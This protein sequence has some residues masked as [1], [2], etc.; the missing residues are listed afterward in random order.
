MTR[1]RRRGEYG[2]D[3]NM[4]GVLG[5]TAVAVVSLMAAVTLA[6]AG[7]VGAAAITALVVA[8]LLTRSASMSTPPA[9]ESSSSGRSFSTA[10]G[11]KVT[12]GCSMSAVPG[13]RS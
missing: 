10:C 1:L 9:A 11:C 4:T 5:M 6:L 8:P 3:G 7:F 13:P 12:N 2:F